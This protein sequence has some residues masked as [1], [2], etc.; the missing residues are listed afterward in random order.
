M[1]GTQLICYI[2]E[3]RNKGEK[4]EWKERG[5]DVSTLVPMLQ[6]PETDPRGLGQKLKATSVSFK[7]TGVYPSLKV[8]KQ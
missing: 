8:L 1:V 5:L 4:E 6:N 7:N 3:G 2:N